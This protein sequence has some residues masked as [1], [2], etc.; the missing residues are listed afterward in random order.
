MQVDGPGRSCSFSS[1]NQA[2]FPRACGPGV[3]EEQ[4]GWEGAVA[5][6]D[7]LRPRESSLGS[8]A[9]SCKPAD[10]ARLRVWGPTP[11]YLFHQCLGRVSHAPELCPVLQDLCPQTTAHGFPT[12]ELSCFQD[13]CPKV[14][15]FSINAD[16]HVKFQ[17]EKTTNFKFYSMRC[18]ICIV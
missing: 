7:P 16:L 10:Y 15:I 13:Q 18:F 12:I 17:I 1:I 14:Y 3:P 6:A 2:A 9:A 11:Q 4:P 5:P 8:L